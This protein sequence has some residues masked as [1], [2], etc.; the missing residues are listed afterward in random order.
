METSAARRAVV[1]A[2]TAAAANLAGGGLLAFASTPDSVQRAIAVA[3]GACVTAIGVASVL[4]RHPRI[5]TTADRVTL[6][7]AVLAGYCATLTVP[8]LAAGQLPGWLLVAIGTTAFLLDGVDGRIARLTG[9]VSPEG[10]RMD[11]E[12]DAALL[13]VL[14]CAAGPQLGWWTLGIG[15]MRYVFVAAAW[16]RPALGAQMRPSQLRRFIGALQAVAL[17][18]ALAPPVPVE[19]GRAG[20]AIALGLLALSFLRDIADLER[21][22]RRRLD[23]PGELLNP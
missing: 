10:A 6:S 23:N 18:L 7:R 3:A 20:V 14:C 15:L 22:R 8:I 1:D 16:F 12:I 17:L 5:T 11:M 9:R 21:W 2:V 13:L 4:R 19:V